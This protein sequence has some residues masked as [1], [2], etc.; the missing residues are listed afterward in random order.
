MVAATEAHKNHNAAIQAIQLARESLGHDLRLTLIGPHGRNEHEVMRR[1]RVA[2]PEGSW[3]CRLARVSDAELQQAYQSA[4]ILIQPSLYEGFGLPVLEAA[5]HG[6]PTV[7]SGR[8]AMPEVVSCSNADS[9]EPEELSRHV[10]RLSDPERYSEASRT[11]LDD[12]R[13]LSPSRFTEDLARL[14]IQVV[15]ENQP[16]AQSHLL[17][18][19]KPARRTSHD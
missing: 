7:H 4:W 14:V 16:A 18:L 10:I 6:T 3:I 11:V 9:I 1:A 17:R 2:D 19:P 15:R 13:R 12:A 8:G 5:A